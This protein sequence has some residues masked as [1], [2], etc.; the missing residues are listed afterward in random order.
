VQDHCL[1]NPTPHANWRNDFEEFLHKSGGA[2]HLLDTLGMTFKTGEITYE[3]LFQKYK[4]YASPYRNRVQ[5]P[6]GKI[7]S[8]PA[9]QAGTNAVAALV[10]DDVDERTEGYQKLADSR[11][12]KLDMARTLL[13]DVESIDEILAADSGE[14]LVSTD[15]YAFQGGTGPGPKLLT[16]PEDENNGTGTD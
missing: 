12:F 11:A 15:T 2:G 5:T 13:E 6:S 9:K 7:T 1:Y 16:E 14:Y 10:S 8:L 4:D 3:W